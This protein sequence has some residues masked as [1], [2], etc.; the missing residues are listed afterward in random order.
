[1][2]SNAPAFI[3]SSACSSDSKTN[4]LNIMQNEKSPYYVQLKR[5]RV[6]VSLRKE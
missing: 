4:K 5:K 6:E 1:M 2:A 3:N